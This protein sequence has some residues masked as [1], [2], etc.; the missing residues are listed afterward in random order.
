MKADEIEPLLPSDA[1][2]QRY[3]ELGYHTT[4]Q[5][6]PHDLLDAAA[7]A[8]K[9]HQSGH[10][11][12]H[13]SA[14][15]RFSDWQPGDKDAVRNNEFASL[16]NDVLRQLVRFPVIGAIAARLAQSAAVRLFDD[17]IV[18]KPAAAGEV[19]TS[20]VV[21]WHT[22]G[23]Y[24]STCTSGKMLT[25]WIPLHDVTAANGTLCVVA[26]SHLWPESDHVRGFNDTNFDGLD[27]RLGRS[28]EKELIHPIELKK[29]EISFH[30]MRALH[31]SMPNTLDQPRCA[32]ALHMQDD[33]NS[34]QSFNT[35]DGSPVVLPHDRL[36][37]ADAAGNPDY[38]DPD[39]FPQLW[40]QVG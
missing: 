20:T 22:D 11:D 5:V 10:R 24:W 9:A 3:C 29:G 37:R 32:V 38:R 19:D 15:A 13:L 30:H 18:Y 33:A 35:P 21:G 4:G 28:V 26:G 2:V 14:D 31:G 36:C 1:D 17:Q 8:L 12:H 16:Q 27:A 34:Y 7:E 40:P 23:S 6:I 39:I 25:A